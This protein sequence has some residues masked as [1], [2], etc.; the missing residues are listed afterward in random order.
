[1]ALQIGESIGHY[2]I[3]EELGFGGNGR[4]LKV[5]HLITRRREAMK[6]LANGRPTSQA[7]KRGSGT[8][9]GT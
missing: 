6:I 3:V 2:Q 1:M 9:A 7:G 5:Q 4:V 8:C